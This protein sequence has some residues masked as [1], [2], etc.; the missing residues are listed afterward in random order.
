MPKHFW[1]IWVYKRPEICQF[2]G[3]CLISGCKRYFSVCNAL[4]HLGIPRL[5]AILFYLMSELYQAISHKY[6]AWCVTSSL[7]SRSNVWCCNRR[8]SQ[9]IQRVLQIHILVDTTIATTVKS[10]LGVTHHAIYLWDIAWY[11]SD[12]R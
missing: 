7:F 1:G 12:I 8:R 4:L 3:K 9:T 2:S 10:W 6:I 5:Y 11:N